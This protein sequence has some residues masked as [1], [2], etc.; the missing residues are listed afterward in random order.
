M[1]EMDIYDLEFWLE[2]YYPTT[3]VYDRHSGE[4]SGG[5]WTCWPVLPNGVP[6]D[7][8]GDSISNMFFWN[9]FEKS[10]VGIGDTPQDAFEDLRNKLKQVIEEIRKDGDFD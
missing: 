10:V 8:Y 5:K 3:I 2:N 7:V 9:S 4:Y 6:Q 1:H